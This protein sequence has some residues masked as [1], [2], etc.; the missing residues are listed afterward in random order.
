MILKKYKNNFLTIIQESGIDPNLFIAKNETISKVDYF[1]VSIRDT[2]IRF[3]VQPLGG[4]FDEFCYRYSIFW[5]G[6]PLC[7]ETYAITWNDLAN[8][9]SKWLTDV[10][11][12]YLD[13]I[14]TPDLRQA[15]QETGYHLKYGVGKPDD[16][17]PFSDEE[18]VQIKLSLVD[19]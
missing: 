8:V 3:A 17:K 18:K 13:D 15:L 5:Q 6:F 16:F 2:E 11:K 12:L 14:S 7:A 9:F 10:V 1:V 4:N 19:F